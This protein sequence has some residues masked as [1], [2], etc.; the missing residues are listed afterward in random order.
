LHVTDLVTGAASAPEPGTIFKIG[1]VVRKAHLAK[2]DGC[3]ARISHAR[4]IRHS[5]ILLCA[6]HSRV[7]SI[8][9][10]SPKEE[11]CAH[12]NEKSCPQTGFTRV[13]LP[14]SQKNIAR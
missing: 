4:S 5:G 13:M 3:R 6:L 14:H 12:R 8:P 7:A 9:G 1:T 11:K 2:Y 10:A